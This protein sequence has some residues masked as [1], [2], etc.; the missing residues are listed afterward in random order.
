MFEDEIPL[1][2]VDPERHAQEVRIMKAI[3][4]AGWY[5]ARIVV[6]EDGK[7][8]AV[9]SVR[10]AHT[11]THIAGNHLPSNREPE[12]MSRFINLAFDPLDNPSKDEAISRALLSSHISDEGADKL[13][14]MTQMLSFLVSI[15]QIMYSIGF[16]PE[17]TTDAMAHTALFVEHELRESNFIGGADFDLRTVAATCNVAV[18][19]AALSALVSLTCSEAGVQVSEMYGPGISRQLLHEAA[20]IWSTNTEVI[21]ATISLFDPTIRNREVVTVLQALQKLAAGEHDRFDGVQRQRIHG[22]HSSTDLAKLIDSETGIGFRR[23][24]FIVDMLKRRT[25]RCTSGMHKIVAYNMVQKDHY[26]LRDS[27]VDVAMRNADGPTEMALRFLSTPNTPPRTV[28]LLSNTEVAAP[29]QERPMRVPVMATARI[30]PGRGGT[31]TEVGMNVPEFVLARLRRVGIMPAGASSGRAN[32][33]IV[34]YDGDIDVALAHLRAQDLGQTRPI[35]MVHPMVVTGVC[36]ALRE[37]YPQWGEGLL[38]LS[39]YPR[40]PALQYAELYQAE[41]ETVRRVRAGEWSNPC[42]VR[43]EGRSLLLGVGENGFLT[44]EDAAALEQFG[45]AGLLEDAP[46]RERA[47]VEAGAAVVTTVVTR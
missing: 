40:V 26:L 22:T 41:K 2:L 19:V 10:T 7:R 35:S 27:A 28:L 6:V 47:D 37:K 33:G 20:N 25:V 18:S 16:L 14:E 31:P 12:L 9:T 17:P 38:P 1:P 29:G 15:F 42:P 45:N 13:F 44:Q 32:H 11:V 34:G 36:Q 43:Y 24:E 30:G 21:M 46:A 3:A 23:A 4:T 8:R 5:E 39:E